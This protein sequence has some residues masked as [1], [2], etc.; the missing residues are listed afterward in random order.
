MNT[1]AK[2]SRGERRAMRVLEHAGYLCTRSGASLGLFDVIAIGPNDVKLIQVKTGTARLSAIER[3]Q[4]TA[5]AVP[6]NASKEVWKFRDRARVPDI[7][8][9]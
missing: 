2:G 1:K 8:R 9:L 3:E 7:E 6:S 5:L 4:I